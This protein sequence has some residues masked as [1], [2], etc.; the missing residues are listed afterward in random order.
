MS[1]SLISG[2]LIVDPYDVAKVASV[3]A[4]LR[5]A[6]IE[7]LRTAFLSNF[8]CLGALDDCVLIA[9]L[10]QGANCIR[11]EVARRGLS[12]GEDIGPEADDW[13]AT[14]GKFRH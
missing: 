4:S 14:S 1:A 9:S 7:S 13:S 5:S 8:R 2:T 6:S 3:R 11:D 12:P 10:V